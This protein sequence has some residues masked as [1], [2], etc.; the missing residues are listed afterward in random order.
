MSASETRAK[1]ATRRLHRQRPSGQRRQSTTRLGHGTPSTSPMSGVMASFM[2]EA[3]A[4]FM[5]GATDREPA[6]GSRP[7]PAG[8]MMVSW[9][10]SA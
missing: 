6:G 4:H 3:D 5:K 8:I 1:G 9:H 2:V 7:L 10:H